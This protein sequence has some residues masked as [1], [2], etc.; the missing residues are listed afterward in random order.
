[1]RTRI[2][3]SAW[4]GDDLV[5]EPSHQTVRL[6]QG[7]HP[8]PQIG[9]CV[10]E[11]ASMLA[12]ESFSD[13]PATVSPVIAA[14]LRTYNDGVDEDR[15][16]ALYP[17][18]SLIVGTTSSRAVERERVSRCLEF[19]RQL[20]AGTP[21]GRAAIGIATAEASGSWAALAAL[22]DGPSSESHSRALTFVREL[23]AVQAQA[24][25]RHRLRWLFGR[26]P[27]QAI[28]EALDTA[29]AVATTGAPEI[30]R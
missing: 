16:Q 22:R 13:R 28:E 30:P 14:F 25:G 27:A 26:D 7:R 23:V 4:I 6:A 8:S 17:L 10:M 18:A 5:M 20:G 1:M 15:R 21:P 2:R 24:P 29:P 11:L 12:G 19:A 9:A 3:E